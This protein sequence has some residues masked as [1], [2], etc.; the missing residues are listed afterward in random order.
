MQ[1]K[2]LLFLTIFLSL[3][4][5]SQTL[6]W[7]GGSGNF[8][9][10]GH[11]SLTSG[12]SAAS[13]R[14]NLNTDLV[15]DDQSSSGVFIVNIVGANQFKSLNC[16][17]AAKELHFTGDQFSSLN[18]SRDF[19]FSH[20][21][22]YDANSKLVF[23]NAT[24]TYNIVNF[25]QNKL[26]ADVHFD[27]GNWEL[28][29]VKVADN[30]AVKFNKGNYRLNNAS[31]VAGSLE[32]N[33]QAVL[34]ESNH[35]ILF[36]KNSLILGQNVSFNS[37]D[38]ILIAPKDNPTAYKV[39]PTVSFGANA[40]IYSSNPG[41]QACAITYSFTNPTCSGQCDASITVGFDSGCNTGPY[42]L[43]F[44]TAAT[45]L[46]SGI[47][48][49][50]PPA[51]TLNSLCACG[52]NLMDIFVFDSNGFVTQ[53]T[54]QNM[55]SNPTPINLFVT[56]PVQPRCFGLC[57]GSFNIT[58][59][60]GTG[61][62]DVSIT[63]GVVTQTLIGVPGVTATPITNLC[64]G[65]YSITITDVKGCVRSF[66][67]NLNQ[68][69]QLLPNGI[70][71][72]VTCFGTCNGSAE[73]SPTG[74]TSPY[75]YSWVSATSTPSTASTSSIGNLCPGVVTMTVTDSQTCTATYSAN[76]TQPTSI[77]VTA[78]T[79][80]LVCS[81]ICN[82]NATITASGGGGG[83][84]YAWTPMGSGSTSSALCAG[85]YSVTV[86]DNLNCSKLV[87]FTLTAPPTLTAS[88][89]QTNVLC[90]SANT[91]AINLNPSG[92]TPSYTYNWSPPVST[93]SVAVNL[94]A[95]VYSYTITD[96]QACPFSGTV[97]ITEP[98]ALSLTVSQTNVTCPS[99]CNG[100]AN[101]NLS[102]GTS[103]YTYTWTP[104]G[105]PLVGQGTASVTNLCAGNYTLSVRDANNCATL[106]TFTITQ[107]PPIATN[108]STVAPTCFSVC[109]GVINSAPSGGWGGPYTFTLIPGTGA[110]TIGSPPFNGLCA[111]SYTLVV[112]D[113]GCTTTQTVTLTQ[114]N[115]L[116]FSLNATAINCFNQCSSTISSVINGGTPSYTVTW[117]SGPSPGN[118][119]VNQCA[120]VH[121]A[122]VTDSKGCTATASV[123]ITSPPDMTV[124][125]NSSDPNCNGQCNGAASTTVTGGTPNYTLSWSNGVT[126]NVNPNLCDGSYTLTATDSRGCVKTGVAVIMA[127]PALTLTP[128]NG[129]VSCSGMCDGNVSVVATGG[130]PGYVYSWSTVP[131]NTNSLVTNLCAGNYNVSVT[132][133]KGCLASTSA[134]VAQPSVLTVTI[135][136]VKPSCNVCIGEAT[137]SGIGG[138]APY[139]Y[140]WS[141][142]G[143]TVASPTDLCVGLQTVTV[144]DS[145]GCVATQTVQINQTIILVLTSNGA[146]LACNGVCSGIATAN[147]VG[148]VLPYTY[149]WTSPPTAPTQTTQSASNLCVGTHT[150]IVTDQLGCS[151]SGTVSF[152][153]PPAITLTVNKADA[154]C[155]SACNGSVSVTASG[156]TGSIS[157][158]WQPGG[159]T[160]SSLIGLCAGDYTLTAT[161][162]N[163]CA[164]TTVVTVAQPSSITV[165]YTNTNPSGCTSSDGSI[166]FTASGGTA[167]INHTWTPGGSVNPLINVPDG[168]YV[169]NVSDANGCI[170]SFTTTL[171]DPLGPTVTATSNSIACFGSC[172]GSASLSITGAGPFNV[173]W[174]AIPSTNTIVTNLCVGS[175]VA[176]VTDANNCIT[177]QTVSIAQPT[178]LTSSGIVSN[179]TCNAA[180]SGAIDL[181]VNGGTPGYT[182]SWTPSGITVP[183]PTT[184]CAGNHSVTIT[185][186]N[187]CTVTNTYVIT[188]PTTVTVT[189]NKQDVLCNGGCTGS[190]RSLVAGGI[191]PYTYSWTPLGAFPGSNIDTIVN[192]CTGVYTVSVTDGNNCV[193][194][195]TVSIGEPAALT[196]TLSSNNITCNGQC[197]GTAVMTATGGV[198]PYTYAYNSIPAVSTPSAGGLCPG[199]YSG[200]VTDANGCTSS[201]SFT[202]TQPLPIVITS[203]VSNPKCNAACDGSVVTTVTGGNPNYSYNWM[204]SGGNVANPTGLCA[205]SYT[206][207][208]TDDSLCTNQA[209]ITLTNPAVL[210]ANTSFTNPTCSG[211]CSGVVTANGAG[212]TAPYTY[213]W[214]APVTNTQTLAGLCAGD[215]TVTVT[216]ANACVRI[217]TVTLVN[218]TAI[219]LNPASTPADCGASNGSIDAIPV[220]GTAP[221]TYTWSPAVSTTSTA[222][223]L[224]AGIYTV[225]VEDVNG[226]SSEVQVPLSNSNGPS[227]VAITFTNIVCN[228][229]N[230]GAAEVSN[231]VGGTAPYTL[232][233]VTPS[234]TNTLITGLGVGTYTAQ[235]TDAN[236]CIYFEGV[237]IT[238]PQLIDDNEA[239]ISPQ[240]FGN[241]NGSITLSPTGGNSGYTYVW[242]NSSSTTTVA[243]SLCPGD[244]S[245]TITDINGCTFS[246][247]YNLPALT[248]IT[249]NTTGVNNICYNNCDGSLAVM[250]V[251]GGLPPYSFQWSDPLGQ[252][253]SQALALCNGVYTVAVTDANGCTSYIPG[254]I[255]SPTAVTFTASVVQPGCDLC[256]GAAVINPVG[257]TPTYTINWSNS[258]TGTSVSNLCAGV[259]AVQ[260]TDGN[261]CLT[262]TNVVINSSSTITGENIVT[263]DETCAGSCNGSATVTAVG[264]VAPITYNWVHDGSTNP[265]QTGLCAGTYFVNMI[266]ANGCSRTTS[267]VINSAV[268][269]TVSSQIA[270]SSCI[271]STGSITVNVSGGTGGYTY[272][273]TPA[274]GS[275]TNVAVNL[276][277]GNY[278]LTV[279]DGNG[280]SHTEVFSMGTINGPIISYSQNNIT[281]S[282]SSSCDGSIDIVINGGTPG[283]TINWS[284]GATNTLS[285]SSL[286][287]GAYSVIV[288]DGAGCEAVQ[289]MNITGVSPL[290]FSSPDL[291]NPVCAND[292]NGSLTVLPIGGTLPYSF[293]WTPGNISTP[294]TSSLCAGNYTVS[295]TDANG[296]NVT[297]T[298]S[299]T[300]PPTMTM[301]AI[302]TQASCN[303]AAD[304]AI[305]LTNGGGVPAYTYS[306]VPGGASTP[307]LT[308]VLP[309]TYSLTITDAGGCSQD[310]VITIISTIVVNAIAGND[311]V[312]CQN[313]VFNLD[314]SN[315]N[316]GTTY[317]WTEL[318]LGTVISNSLVVQVSPATGTNTYVLIATNGACVDS[319]S[320]L[321]TSSPLPVVDAGPMVSIPL[322]GTAAIGGNPTGPGG[323]TFNWLPNSGLDNPVGANPVSSTT[324]TTIYTVSVTDA[325]G[326]MNSDTVTVYVYPQ[327]IIPNGFSPNADGKN[328]TWMLDLIT[329]FPDCEVEVYNRWGEQLLYSKGYPIPWNGQYKG[330]DLPVGTYYYVINLNHPAYPDPYT[331]PLTIFR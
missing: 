103:P 282:S 85:P 102:G 288:V 217:Q 229:Q 255:I 280:C 30:Y 199:T 31:V 279:T 149:N 295:I 241:C 311:T 139:S 178:Q 291:D 283:G 75:T 114:P 86:T 93:N 23:S 198:V 183:D 266:D 1:R 32:S 40:K 6:Y 16:L 182:Y 10:G 213:M 167:P 177:N 212:G 224:G 299:L 71:N 205:G 106:T 296:C 247:A 290:A 274:V 129:T 14:P 231:P 52:G 194:V 64:S 322:F 160:T 50:M 142:G 104:G 91:G 310:T 49:V 11:W 100:A 97:A 133:S 42:D 321:V 228:G 43:I 319:D 309:G 275:T 230:N 45:C 265:T 136:N 138:T 57:N 157:Y 165:T 174:P 94:P 145:R 284:N 135:S 271:S 315:S 98:P 33:S 297:Q 320:I 60:G 239:L 51:V 308:N 67:T 80:N 146:T 83:Y 225:T 2:L 77:T 211:V 48:G 277:P 175:Y 192:L 171:S 232:V 61:P 248:T 101:A 234:T 176:S 117:A 69:P 304:G 193:T 128:V 307:D 168:S 9:D 216:D 41:V 140:L 313:G 7:V 144:T 189:F 88:P 13:I 215:Y 219:S 137:A 27:N 273:W 19:V 258:Q 46:P 35:S 314:G 79:T 92:G 272:V 305:D 62:Y 180:C 5:K 327:I 203:T 197:N 147:G 59:S 187:N 28:Q 112:G 269:L 294:T 154:S 246:G 132:D 17:N 120:G 300:S 324:I 122:T 207:I 236:G 21:T 220:G 276:A 292:C 170:Q 188:Q 222:V 301:T 254:E 261:G 111:G 99:V 238:E 298:Y 159:A 38:L 245:V 25:K 126:G 263:A 113:N 96:S 152:A 281:C 22:Y 56:S 179:V 196:S 200:T 267:V 186:L 20:S 303:N 164:Q 109:N 26:D 195:A 226:C 155:N 249:S 293:N 72:S 68:P 237:S 323:S 162:A 127:P 89:T 116:S 121:T 206:V 131:A 242:I 316:G 29:S 53:L 289:N 181:T 150:V 163:G 82:G 240:C 218:P 73:V 184:L 161:D 287:A 260:I 262:D 257:G 318:P 317:Q 252:S 148:G 244:Y 210:I 306:W 4:I 158:Q 78:N 44:N 169:L 302:V 235:V 243:S 18:C 201:N 115:L 125:I 208:V 326:C 253:A 95:Q 37:S 55:P 105:A 204:P 330:K 286:C 141:P 191:A 66:T 90:S 39:N 54:G 268:T 118:S 12:G 227:D 134:N 74:G 63:N 47:N 76:V 8:N 156:G 123:N 278:S 151:S 130:T 259:Y 251:A 250:N 221:Y 65:I 24:A 124:T 329:L 87:T 285:I 214:A 185:D 34:F 110:P 70:T 202:I 3:V 172:T 331:G 107:P 325:N 108:V 270:Q 209:I 58:P 173:N 81:T 119:Q 166:E 143:Q 84:T 328:D 233:W 36:A 153:Q 264:G 256:D 223:N 312:F 15:F 190:V